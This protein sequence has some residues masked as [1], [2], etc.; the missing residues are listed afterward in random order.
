[1]SENAIVPVYP[2]EGVQV[3]VVGADQNLM[4]QGWKTS[5]PTIVSIDKWR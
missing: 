4:M 1:M 5:N 2:R 3:V